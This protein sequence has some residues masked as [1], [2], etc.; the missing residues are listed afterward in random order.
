LSFISEELVVL[1]KERLN[2]ALRGLGLSSV[3][4]HVF[5]F[6]ARTGPQTMRE[7]ASALNLPE[8]KARRSLKD[9]QNLNIV[10][11]SVEYPLE[12]MAVPFEEVVNLII[13]VKKE[14]AKTL[15][16][17][18]EELISSWRSITEKDYEKS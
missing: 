5:V 10:Q 17:S 8:R 3:D 7:I 16:A 2:K 15:Q 12:F 11:A 18:K 1:S 9:L 13:E 4:V 14:Q 6:L